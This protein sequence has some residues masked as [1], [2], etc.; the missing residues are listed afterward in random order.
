MTA[1]AKN[2][3]GAV[4]K[5]AVAGGSLATIAE[6]TSI[7]PPTLTRGTIDATTHD[8]ASQAMEFIADGVFDPGEISIE[9]NLILGSAADDL[10]VAAVTTGALYDFELVGKAA[11][12]TESKEGSCI[13]TS[14]APGDMP[15]SGGKQTFTATLKVTGAITQAPTA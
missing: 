6:L 5:L 2:T 11:T 9:G 10:F 15:V 8:G 12:G 7:T 13:V 3:F 14:Y 4:L 1:A